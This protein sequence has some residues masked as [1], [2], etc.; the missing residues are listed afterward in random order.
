MQTF[1]ADG[2]ISYQDPICRKYESGT[3]MASFKLAVQTGHGKYRRTDY[4]DCVAYNGIADFIGEHLHRKDKILIRATV[5]NK[6][7]IADGKPIF[8]N[9]IVVDS[10][11]VMRSAEYSETIRE[12]AVSSMLETVPESDTPAQDN[13]NHDY[14]ELDTPLFGTFGED[15]K[16]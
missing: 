10:L 8:R 9:R 6:S 16:Q 2:T 5:Q 11:E 14:S 7:Y 4:L 15:D 12:Q 13:E 3:R 1:I